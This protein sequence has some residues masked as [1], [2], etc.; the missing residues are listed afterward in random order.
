MM[1]ITYAFSRVPWAHW[2]LIID[3][4]IE[5]P[6]H[7]MGEQDQASSSMTTLCHW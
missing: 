7:L 2:V 5:S 3:V 6:G 4:K 1:T